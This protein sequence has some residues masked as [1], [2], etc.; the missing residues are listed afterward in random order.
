MTGPAEFWHWFDASQAVDDGGRP[1]V[2]YHATTRAFSRFSLSKCGSVRSRPASI[3]HLGI[4]FASDPR[5]AARIVETN[6][7][8]RKT[9]VPGIKNGAHIRP[10]FLRVLSPHRPTV[11]EFT[12]YTRRSDEGVRRLRAE[13]AASGFDGVV[14][15]A[16]GDRLPGDYYVVFDPSQIVPALGAAAAAVRGY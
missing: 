6:P 7:L 13:L 1:L 9:D 15:P 12:A 11:E 16:A 2:T 8:K 10:A 5:A 14:V 4:F 3:N